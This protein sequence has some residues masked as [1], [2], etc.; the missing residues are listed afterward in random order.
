MNKNKLKLIATKNGLQNNGSKPELRKMIDK[1]FAENMPNWR[2]NALH[3]LV[4]KRHLE[5]EK[6]TPLTALSKKELQT[7]ALYF[8]KNH[9]CDK[10]GFIFKVDWRNALNLHLK[11]L[12][13]DAQFD[14]NNLIILTPAMFGQE[15]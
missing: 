1:F 2:R 4:F 9:I 3:Q 7:V 10:T 14:K 11:A 5:L 13:P 12:F 6:P 8:G 15:Q